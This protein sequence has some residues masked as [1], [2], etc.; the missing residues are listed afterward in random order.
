M[1][2]EEIMYVEK[3]NFLDIVIHDIAKTKILNK[4]NEK[5]LSKDDIRFVNRIIH[6]DTNRVS[7]EVILRD[8]CF[9]ILDDGNEVN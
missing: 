1:S 6:C 3:I 4:L 8:D 2:K 7:Y 9:T 5:S